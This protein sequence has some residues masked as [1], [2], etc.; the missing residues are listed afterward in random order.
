MK[1]KKNE[2]EANI[3]EVKCKSPQGRCIGREIKDGCTS[4]FLVGDLQITTQYVGSCMGGETYFV[5]DPKEV[6]K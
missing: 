3:H 5:S 2:V 1:K 6:H 4:S